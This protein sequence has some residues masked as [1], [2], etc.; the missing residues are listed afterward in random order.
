M[1]KKNLQEGLDAFVKG[2][3]LEEGN[4]YFCEKCD[5]KVDALKRTCF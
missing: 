2:D 4:Q 5:K 1:N 3:M